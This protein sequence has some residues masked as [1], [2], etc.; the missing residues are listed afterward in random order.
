MFRIDLMLYKELTNM[1]KSNLLFAVAFIFT[2]QFGYSQTEK[3]GEKKEAQKTKTQKEVEKAE[4]KVNEANETVSQTGEAVKNSINTTK[5]TVGEVKGAITDIFGKK[6]DKPKNTF[7]I[8]VL[9]TDLSNSAVNQLS[10]YITKK[11]LFK[12]I[13]KSFKAGKVSI[14]VVPKKNQLV[15]DEIPQNIKNLFTILEMD[16]KKLV[17]QVKNTSVP[18]QNQPK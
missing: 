2:L 12:S 16:D 10:S 4:R 15:W 17:L 14:N 13:S 18:S 1:K 5:E 7:T 11:K 8:A 6:K 9:Q 3:S